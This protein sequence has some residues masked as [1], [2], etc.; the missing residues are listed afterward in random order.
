M[1]LGTPIFV[2]KM[3]MAYD[4]LKAIIFAQMDKS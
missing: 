1:I 2:S 4:N 3:L